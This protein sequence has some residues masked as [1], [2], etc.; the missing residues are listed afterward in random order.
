[1]LTEESDAHLVVCPLGSS[2]VE[3]V[4][5]NVPPQTVDSLLFGYIVCEDY[6]ILKIW[7]NQQEVLAL[8]YLANEVLK[9]ELSLLLFLLT[10]SPF[11]YD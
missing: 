7:R 6:L 10:K 8:K 9:L 4:H 11:Y 3:D 1:M 2:R 5:M